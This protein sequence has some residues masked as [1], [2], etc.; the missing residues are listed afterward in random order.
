MTDVKKKADNQIEVDSKPAS[1]HP[2]SL[3][4]P[5][6]PNKAAGL[7]AVAARVSPVGLQIAQQL[8]RRGLSSHLRHRRAGQ[9]MQPNATAVRGHLSMQWKTGRTAQRRP[10]CDI[11]AATSFLSGADHASVLTVFLRQVLSGRR[12]RVEKIYA[13]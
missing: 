7:L 2:P 5:S 8:A 13:V 1:R 4:Y 10:I 12:V 3:I 9:L 6:S 11:D